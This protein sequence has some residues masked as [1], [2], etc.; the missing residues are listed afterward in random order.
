VPIPPGATTANAYAPNI[1]SGLVEFGSTGNPHAIMWQSFLGGIQYYLPPSGKLWVSANYSHM[2][3][4]DITRFISAAARP[5]VYTTAE[6]YDFNLFCDV[7][8]AARLGVEYAHYKQTM[9]DDSTR[10]NDR[11]QFSGWLIF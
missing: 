5:S 6:W 3:S 10:K 11:V 7:T 4:N 2:K 8:I 1:D 9:G